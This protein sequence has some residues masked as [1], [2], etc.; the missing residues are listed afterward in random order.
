MLIDHSFQ[1]KLVTEFQKQ[2][3]KAQ[4]EKEHQQEFATRIKTTCGCHLV[5]VFEVA[6]FNGTWA[7][8]Y[9]VRDPLDSHALGGK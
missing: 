2:I 3:D 4:Y 1:F 5:E 7:T 6:K 9:S 8:F